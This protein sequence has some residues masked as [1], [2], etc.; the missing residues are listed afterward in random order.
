MN[1][2]ITSNIYLIIYLLLWLIVCCSH[3]KKVKLSS[4]FVVV[5]SYLVYGIFAY[6]LYSDYFLGS[7]Y[8]ELKL[9]P[10]LYL[11]TMM[12]IFL[13]PVFKYEKANVFRIKRPSTQLVQLFLAVYGICALVLLPNILSSLQEG[14]TLLLLDSEG[15]SELYESAHMDYEK[16]SA[17]VSG[18]Y[19]MFSIFYNTFSDV[20]K[21]FSFYYLTVKNKKKILILLFCIVFI[22]DLLYP[23]SQGGRTDVVMNMFSMIMALMLFYPFYSGRVQKVTKSMSVVLLTIVAIPFMAL[24]ISRFGEKDSGTS[25]GILMYAGQAPLNFN[26]NALDVG[27]TRNGDRTINLFKQFIFENI[28]EDVDEVRAKY[29]HLKMDD[30][31]FSTYVG[32]FVL[33]YGP[34]GAFVVFVCLSLYLN[35]KIRIVNRTISFRAL[36]LVYFILCVAMQGGMYLFYYSFVR[37]LR[38][39][40]I[41]FTYFLLSVYPNS[42]R[43]TDYLYKDAL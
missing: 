21:F 13:I 41:I 39:M 34:I 11:F 33:D 38:I 15:G 16:R 2:D 30:S 28:P 8:R 42:H 37:N 10:F 1:H 26:I 35:S 12:Y 7:S 43:A 32:D 4:G 14:I 31:I 22:I 40:A 9:F 19:G 18:I 23:I 29:Q 27:G 5:T 3:Y 24:T 20:A 17:G 36:L 6:L 25:G